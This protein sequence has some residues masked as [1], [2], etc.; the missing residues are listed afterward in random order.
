MHFPSSSFEALP[1]LQTEAEAEGKRCCVGALIFNH[2]GRLLL[3][4]RSPDRKLFPNCWDIIGGH[5]EPGET[6]TAA[7][8]REIREETG[9]EL[10]CL[11]S[12]V[13]ICEWEAEPYGTRREFDFLVE[14]E[15]DLEHPRLEK[16]KHT[17]FRWIN[18]EDLDVLKKEQLAGGN[19]LYQMVKKAL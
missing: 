2:Q 1:A 8:A 3:Q 19:E 10:S 4:K 7:L 9:W 15:G 11:I 16:G 5:V 18:L 6:L 14:V 17:A 12:L 13:H